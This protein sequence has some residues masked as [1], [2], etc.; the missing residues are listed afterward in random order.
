M[1][2]KE[3]SQYF[4]FLIIVLLGCSSQFASD[5]YSPCIVSISNDL[6][7]SINSVQYSMSLY[8]LGVAISQLIFG[9][10]SEGIGR[11]KTII[12]GVSIATIG[13]IITIFAQNIETIIIG[14]FIQGFGNGAPAS[15]WRTILR[16][17]HKDREL[18]KY[19][20]YSIIYISF[21]V[22]LA[23][24]LGGY[25]DEYFSWHSNFIFLFFYSSLC[26]II[27]I[28]I[29]PETNTNISK[30]KLKMDYV[31]AN[32]KIILKSKHFMC[33]SLSVLLTYGTK[34]CWFIVSPVLLIDKLGITSFEFGM[35]NFIGAGC[36]F[37]I[38][39]ILNGKLVTSVGMKNMMRIGFLIMFTAGLSMYIFYRIYDM[40][41]YVI[42]GPYVM[43]YFGST[44][45][46]PN[47]FSTAFTPFGKIAGFAGALYG[48]MQI[49][50]GAILGSIVA[51]LP[52]ENQEALALVMTVTT[53]IAFLSYEWGTYKS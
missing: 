7:V 37:F 15:L 46:W 26:L 5:I 40:N 44:F 34:A 16:D 19:T 36:S 53:I 4:L 50:G 3:S 45:F 2:N 21:I 13:T 30:S 28:Y 24:L 18:A 27:A 42:I 43:F 29:L 32:F 48:F 6:N 35:I 41:P 9:P 17:L 25:L 47:A 20:S 52:D 23:P 12:L 22:P 10:L 31:F 11:K 1:S 14:R 49:S 8:M 39:G 33:I 38:G 51:Y